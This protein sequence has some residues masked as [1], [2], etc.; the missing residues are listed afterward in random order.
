MAGKCQTCGLPFEGHPTKEHEF[1]GQSMERNIHEPTDRDLR[2]IEKALVEEEDVSHDEREEA[3]TPTACLCAAATLERSF[4]EILDYYE[5]TKRIG[6]SR[7]AVLAS[8][9]LEAL[10][11]MGEFCGLKNAESIAEG[12]NE[13]YE[14]RGKDRD[15]EQLAILE[16]VHK[17]W[18][19]ATCG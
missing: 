9:G 2:A 14:M 8:D 17:A 13:A 18:K 5:R 10:D 11:V 19:E 12:I 16:K 6:R 4:G 3:L 15:H 7:L 1:Q